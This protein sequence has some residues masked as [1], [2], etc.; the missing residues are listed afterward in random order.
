MHIA[1]QLRLQGIQQCINISLIFKIYKSMIVFKS[2]TP[3]YRGK[4]TGNLPGGEGKIRK[5]L[6]LKNLTFR[7]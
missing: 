1:V 3:F 2:V 6:D 5:F 7:Q 4:T